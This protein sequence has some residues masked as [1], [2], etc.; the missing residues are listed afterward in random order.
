MSN[1]PPDPNNPPPEGGY[2]WEQPP[3]GPAQPGWDQGQ[4]GGYPPQG[5]WPQDPNAPQY[6]QPYDPSQYP[7]QWQQGEGWQPPQAPGPLPHSRW[8]IAS[9]VTG[10]VGT[11]VFI[12]MQI[13]GPMV[14]SFEPGTM[15]QNPTPGDLALGGLSCCSFLMIGVALVLAIIGCFD[16][17]SNRIT[18][19]VALG[20]LGFVMCCL[21]GLMALGV[22]V[23]MGGGLG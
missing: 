17:S 9:I 4:Y 2:T 20:V 6:Q 22:A 3:E 18:A 16:K 10:A 1:Q 14:A 23:I 7:P 13:V 19:Y 12:I 8:G 15:P 5:Q 11:V 21:G